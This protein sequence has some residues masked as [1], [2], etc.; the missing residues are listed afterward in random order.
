MTLGRL[1]L[2]AVLVA[3]AACAP[4]TSSPPAPPPA[5]APSVSLMPVDYAALPGW[6]ED[7]QAQVLPAFR[8]SC[9]RI[10]QMPPGQP[11]GHDGGVAGDWLGPCGALRALA[12]SDDRA[13][14]AFFETWFAP[15]R[16]LAN[17]QGDGL[18][19]GYYEA[20]LH[21]AR[22]PDQ[23]Y[24]VPIYGRP[25][26]LPAVGEAYFSRA[27][28]EAGALNG[29]VRPL[30]WVDDPVDAH[31]LHI[32]GSGRILMEDGTIVRVGFNGSNG[33]PFVGLGK[34]LQTHGKLQPGDTTMQAV[35]AWLKSH[36]AEAPALMA[37]NP[38]YV[39]FRLITGDGPVGAAGVALTPG[40]SLAVDP[41]FVAY[42]T[43]LW[44]D[45]ADPDGHPLRRLMVAQ[46]TGTAIKGAIRGDVYWG[47][48]EPAMEIA[49]RM[50]SRGGYFLLLP[51]NRTIPVASAGPGGA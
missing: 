3:L 40:R 24:R 14:R 33:H 1:A 8:R 17:G 27:E 9:Q 18:F 30:L 25:D 37:E 26:G 4:L 43:P 23:R 35:R 34:I 22:R 16:V 32:Q 21:G 44:L 46:D 51:R 29:S 28:I 41:R 13:A 2:A 39:F 50:K 31:I 42:G 5:A 48:G 38:R 49:G 7:S 11:L 15:F 47:S 6:A 45:A 12:D 36:P 19:T 10:A 20:E